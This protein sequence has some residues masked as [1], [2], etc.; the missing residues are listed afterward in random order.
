M[1]LEASK[2]LHISSGICFIRICHVI[3]NCFRQTFIGSLIFQYISIAHLIQQLL[4]VKDLKL[5]AHSYYF[6]KA[7][8]NVFKCEDAEGANHNF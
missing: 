6:H 2:K 1:K 7:L 5:I 8:V 3:K 4:C